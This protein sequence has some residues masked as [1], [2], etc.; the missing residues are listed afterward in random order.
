M[1]SRKKQTALSSA[2]IFTAVFL[3]A[4]LMA[5]PLEASFRTEVGNIVHAWYSQNFY[6]LFPVVFAALIALSALAWRRTGKVP[7]GQNTRIPRIVDALRTLIWLPTAALAGY[8][9]P[10]IGIVAAGMIMPYGVTFICA[11]TFERLFG[12]SV[13]IHASAQQS[14]LFTWPLLAYFI[15]LLVAGLHF[16][17]EIGPRSGDEIHY[18][19]QLKSLT[20][21]G[22]LELTEEMG[23]FIEE[24]GGN[25]LRKSHIRKNLKGKL[26]SFHSFGLPLLTWPLGFLGTLGRQ[27]ILALIGVLSV[28]GCRAACLAFKAPAKASSLVS[29]TL[30]FSYVWAMYAVRFLPE[31]LGCGLVAWAFWAVISQKDK[32]W[33]GTVVAMVSCGFLPYAHIRFAPT[34]LLL[35][36]FFGIEGLF[37]ANEK[38]SRKALRLSFFAAGYAVFGF[39]LL[40]SHTTMYSGTQAYDYDAFFFSYPKAMWAILADRR[41]LFTVL[42]ALIWMI[43]SVPYCLFRDRNSALRAAEAGAVFAATL[44]TCC[45]SDV[46]FGGGGTCIP[47][48]FLLTSVPVLLPTAAIMLSRAK[49]AARIWFYFL[50]LIPVLFYVFVGSLMRESP[51]AFIRVPGKLRE[52]IGFQSFWEPLASFKYV[53]HP[54]SILFTSVFVIALIALTILLVALRPSATRTLS[55]SAILVLAL[56]CGYRS[57]ALENKPTEKILRLLSKESNWKYYLTGK[58]QPLDIVEFFSVPVDASRKPTFILTDEASGQSALTNIIPVSRSSIED[59][60]GRNIFW[61]PVQVQMTYN[62]EG[63]FVLRVVGNVKR[64]TGL[65][66]LRQGSHTL[67]DCY[68]VGEGAFDVTWVVPTRKGWGFTGAV[69]ALKDN[70]GELEIDSVQLIPFSPYM[71]SSGFVFPSTTVVRDLSIK[72][73]ID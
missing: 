27:I 37:L 2:I 7:A 57:N 41:S 21:T 39:L 10:W 1:N 53:T 30:A 11:W 35:A 56:A 49:K 45:S 18:L 6:K 14:R 63:F 59:W 51:S 4:L 40:Y 67:E 24:H 54:E 3:F 23:A 71:I 26:Y 33:P 29:W 17:K 32:R 62:F 72:H 5:F 47:G 42:P 44:L 19:T 13:Q 69:V 73:P 64:G 8:T 48:R 16:Q 22:N 12:D 60:D 38:T 50:A 52:Y 34:S 46:S 28:A 68:A 58:E 66:S 43:V 20:E 70:R 25:V 9:A 61:H 55:C 65:F 15:L 36:A 31:I